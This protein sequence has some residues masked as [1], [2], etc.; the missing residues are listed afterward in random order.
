MIS[1]GENLKNL[2]KAANITQ[3]ELSER[4]N[5]HLQTVSKWERGVF[6][7]DVSQ[8]GELSQIFGVS[9]ECLLGLEDKGKQTAGYFDAQKFGRAICDS[10]T[11]KGESQAQLAAEIGVSADTV[12]RWERGVTCPDLERLVALAGHFGVSVS[13]LYCGAAE[14][15]RAAS[16]KSAHKVRKRSFRILL[17]AACLFLFFAGATGWLLLW[18]GFVSEEKPAVYDVTI[19][20]VVYRYAE[21]D[22]ILP[23][24][25]ERTGYVLQGWQDG[26]GA[27]VSFPILAEKDASYTPVFVPCEYDV[28]Y[29]L[30][31]GYF[32]RSPVQSFTV[33][34]GLVQLSVPEKMGMKFEGWYLQPDYSGEAVEQIECKGS[35]VCLYAKWEV[36][37]YTI[38]YELDGGVLSEPNPVSV[39]LQKEETLHRPI[40]KGYAFLGWYDCPT[41]GNRYETV[42][43]EGAKN[44]TLY[45]RWQKSDEIYTITYHADGGVAE[46]ENPVSVGAGEVYP[47][48]SAQKTGYEFLGWCDHADGEGTCYERLYGIDRSLE[49]YA[50]YRAKEYL[51]RYVYEGRYLTEE[52]NPN[53]IVYGQEAELLPVYRFGYEFLGWYDA[54]EG[55]NLISAINE[56]VT[57]FSVLYAVFRPKEFIVSLH[58]A[59]GTIETEDGKQGELSFSVTFGEEILL[60]SCDRSGYV[61]CGWRDESGKTVV[62]IG[63]GIDSDLVLTAAW[64]RTGVVYPIEY[65]LNGGKMQTDS[66]LSANSDT[67]LPLSEPYRDE[68]LF[69]GWF[70][71]PQGE[72]KPYTATPLGREEPL[73]LY[74]LWQDCRVSGSAENFD[75]FKSGASVTITAYKGG[76]GTGYVVDVPAI[77]EGLP[78]VALECKMRG[79]YRAIHLPDGIRRLGE[80]CF[81]GVVTEQPLVIPAGVEEIGAKCFA[82]AK[83]ELY[84]A[85]GNSIE[86]IGVSAFERAEIKNVLTLP[87][88]VKILS[89]KAFFNAQC[90]GIV[91]PEGLQRIETQAL[92]APDRQFS[93]KFLYLPAGL[94]YIGEAAVAIWNDG[95]VYAGF[96]ETRAES[97]AK[98]W[99]RNSPCVYDFQ[100]SLVT[101][102][103]G[104]KTEQLSGCSFA[105]PRPEKNGYRFLGWKDESGEFVPLLFIPERDTTLTA[106]Y[107]LKTDSDGSGENAPALVCCGEER[108]FYGTK[109]CEFYFSVD[110]DAPVSVFISVD[111]GKGEGIL[112]RR[113]D[114]GTFAEV[115]GGVVL[116]MPSDLFRVTISDGTMSCI[117]K[118]KINILNL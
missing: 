38:R 63:A 18:S 76:S 43:G 32:L 78:V 96:S 90:P 83:T 35:S 102:C 21:G 34:S 40:R 13:D 67:S 37:S 99:I 79:T 24:A 85:E 108:V 116:C 2:R 31:G 105:L 110:T 50:M 107:E 54:P 97:F 6:E 114:D 68:F 60:P 117:F 4:L 75:Y 16:Q 48:F 44:V 52:T 7:P 5:I 14:D 77:I 74:A 106:C 59:G 23:R 42:G 89:A 73:T 29:W 91:L 49:L 3:S 66:P 12:S 11:K 81:S 33:E 57:T 88:S 15:E 95:C 103:D 112:S 100:P 93:W 65:V 17:A 72:G 45:A 80:E 70:D 94:M 47:L 10:R 27:S 87:D 19:D 39:T 84:F 26:E 58:G 111:F 86:V 82:D 92:I 20:G 53:R 22:M 69:L 113:E 56:N 109:G 101:F 46:G 1:F 71:N 25:P 98:V 104:A 51:I 118:V 9:L 115:P 61:F 36:V 8:L 64:K 30:N 28:D 55:G 62:Q 41:G